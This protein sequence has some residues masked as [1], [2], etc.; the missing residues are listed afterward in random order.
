M[1]SFNA[2]DITSLLSHHS[3]PFDEYLLTQP[4]INPSREPK[5]M[6]SY[7]ILNFISPSAPMC[8][9]RMA[10]PSVFF[11]AFGVFSRLRRRCTGQGWLGL[12]CLMYQ[13][14]MARRSMLFPAFSA[15]VLAKDGLAFGA[16]FR[17]RR[18]FHGHIDMVI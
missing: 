6:K 5:T 10:W 7:Y 15:D 8:R 13:L 18:F 17:L 1:E 14:K 16:F 11:S 2:F 3:L 4:I 9:P 12:R